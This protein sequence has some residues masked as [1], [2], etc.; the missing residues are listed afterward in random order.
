[1]A[2]KNKGAQQDL[3]D[4]FEIGT[5]EW[6]I[7]PAGDDRD[8]GDFFH[9][10]YSIAVVEILLQDGIDIRHKPFHLLDRRVLTLQ[11]I[12]FSLGS[13]GLGSIS[14]GGVRRES[15]AEHLCRHIEEQLMNHD[16]GL[17][18]PH[19][20]EIR[21][22]SRKF[23]NRM[24]NEYTAKPFETSIYNPETKTFRRAAIRI[25][26]EIE[27]NDGIFYLRPSLNATN[28]YLGALDLSL[29]DAQ[30]ALQHLLEH[31]IKKGMLKDAFRT[32]KELHTKTLAYKDRILSFERQMSTNIHNVSWRTQ[33][34]PKLEEIQKVV[35]ALLE[36][37]R[38]IRRGIQENLELREG[39]RRELVTE[40]LKAI[41]DCIAVTNG[42]TKIVVGLDTLYRRE[43]ERQG[44]FSRSSHR[45]PSLKDEV[46]PL[47]MTISGKALPEMT[48]RLITRISPPVANSIF[49]LKSVVMEALRP[50]RIIAE[51]ETDH[52]ELDLE[53]AE[54]KYFPNVTD[55][56]IEKAKHLIEKAIGGQGCL[57]SK[58]I[59]Q[60]YDADY[61][62]SVLH[63]T[64]LYV[65]AVW[66]IPDPNLPWEAFLA[67]ATFTIGDITCSDFHLKPVERRRVA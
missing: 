33:I 53:G 65:Q 12:A 13:L 23:V 1:M 37:N 15:M 5:T 40:L 61:S 43:Q 27:G 62:F 64:C 58:V 59:T 32:S 42:L 56:D 17:E 26:E 24:A 31:Q 19:F 2:S 57:L 16:E 7:S 9:R 20:D 54:V 41:T 11:A 8:E 14:A 67:N 3:F 49:D 18:M 35:P 39:N 22:F 28:L 66:Q 30:F 48:D 63:A 55:A 4:P 51:S 25:F 60:A 34:G 50:R 52:L 21:V 47:M 29:E 46:L 36:T 38:T 44:F 10:A 6:N 45:L